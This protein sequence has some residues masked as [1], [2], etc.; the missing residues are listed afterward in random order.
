MVG[1]E[2][3]IGIEIVK[4][5]FDSDPDLDLLPNA[6]IVV[7]PPRERCRFWTG[8][9]YHN[10]WGL[11]VAALGAIGRENHVEGPAPVDPVGVNRLDEAGAGDGFAAPVHGIRPLVGLLVGE[12]V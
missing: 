12:A 1:I 2:I 4:R 11:S 5:D 7:R 8:T 10:H 9:L 6:D 3:A